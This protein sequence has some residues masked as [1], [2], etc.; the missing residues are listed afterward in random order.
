MGIAA[1]GYLVMAVSSIGLPSKAE[2]VAIGG[3]PDAQRVTPF[4]LIGTYLI[5]TIA[6]LFISPLGISFVSKIA[7]PQYKGLMQGVWF[8][9]LAIGSY[10]V[11][12]ISV[13]WERLNLWELWL[14][15]VTCCIISAV[16]MFSMLKRLENIE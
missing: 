5:L 1:L 8:A 15:L 2:V 6:E 11:G 13:L 14:I 16:V 9:G 10:L 7:P 3:L 4:L 12:I